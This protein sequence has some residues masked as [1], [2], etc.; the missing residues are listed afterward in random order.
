[1]ILFL[2]AGATILGHFFAVT[3]TPFMVADWLGGLNIG[4]FW[5]IMI[6]MVV[7]LIGG[8]SYLKIPSSDFGHS[9]FLA[10]SAQAR[11]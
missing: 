3:R 8:Y 2:V 10:G 9:H 1:M 6:I 4:A 5:V 11:L 7:Y